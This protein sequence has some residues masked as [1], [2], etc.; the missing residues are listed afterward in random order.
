MDLR[1]GGRYRPGERHGDPRSDHGW[2]IAH[3]QHGCD[4]CDAADGFLA[5]LAD[6]VGQRAQQLAVNV[7]G[8][9][10]HTRHDTG[11]LRLGAVQ[12]G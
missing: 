1:G 12:S 9:P 5:E 10:A 11:E 6:A 2:Q 8:R 3:L 4:R 7:D